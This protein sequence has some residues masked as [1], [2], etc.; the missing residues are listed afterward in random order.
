MSG[1]NAYRRRQSAERWSYH[2][3]SMCH[4]YLIALGR[5]VLTHHNETNAKVVLPAGIVGAEELTKVLRALE[6]ARQAGAR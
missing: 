6:I 4:A 5:W 1:R 3:T 2:D